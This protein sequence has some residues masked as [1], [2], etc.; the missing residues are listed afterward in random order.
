M[1]LARSRPQIGA[2]YGTR[3][4]VTAVKGHYDVTLHVALVHKNVR[5][6]RGP[7]GDARDARGGYSSKGAHRE[8]DFKPHTARTLPG[9]D[10]PRLP[11]PE[12]VRAR[13]AAAALD[14]FIEP[15]ERLGRQ[16]PLG[17]GARAG[18]EGDVESAA[19]VLHQ[20]AIGAR[21]HVAVPA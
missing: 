7:C 9:Y 6:R 16:L 11:D 20:P 21:P 8:R 13:H 4:R 19:L 17:V 2:P 10:L 18:E 14:V 1:R 15:A 3:T 5:F 12:S